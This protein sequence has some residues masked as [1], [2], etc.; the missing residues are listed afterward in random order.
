MTNSFLEK[1]YEVP[2]TKSNYLKFQEGDN[3]FRVLSSA[4]VGWQ[5]FTAQNKPVRSRE[6][7]DGIPKDIKENGKV[8]H[9]WAFICYD[10]QSESIK[11]LEITQVS[12]M[13]AIKA[14]IDNQKWG[15][16]FLYDLNVGR[17]GE[18]LETKYTVQ[19]EPPIGE[20]SEDIKKKYLDVKI[21][22]QKLYTGENPFME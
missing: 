7:F 16:I 17:T 2:E 22:L 15:N 9:F 18:G 20:V 14:L 8:K 3:R 1:S 21:D 19:P 10:Y 12:I 4:I 6:P 5:Y 11:I 13:E